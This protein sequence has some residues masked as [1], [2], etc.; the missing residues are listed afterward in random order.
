MVRHVRGLVLILAAALAV[1]LVGVGVFALTPQASGCPGEDAAVVTVKLSVAPEIEPAVARAVERFNDTDQELSG[2]CVR[3]EV[4]RAEPAQ[5]TTLLGQG[6]ALGAESR[7]DAW[8]PDSSLWPAL[9]ESM[10]QDKG[11]VEVTNV[12]VARSLIVIGMPQTLA[13]EL[14]GRGLSAGAPSWNS[15]LSAGSGTPTPPSR[16]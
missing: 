5:L 6:S 16:G 1:G 11:S 14:R 9:L 12:S 3:A 10:T 8:I 4:T 13:E 15:L 7:P 2:T